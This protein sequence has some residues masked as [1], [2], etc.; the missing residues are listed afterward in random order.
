MRQWLRHIVLAAC[1]LFAFGA[2]AQGG[3]GAFLSLADRGDGRIDVLFV[4]GHVAFLAGAD[5]CAAV[6]AEGMAGVGID[7]EGSPVLPRLSRLV[8]L[9]RGT[10]LAL[11][12]ATQTSGVTVLA[13]PLSAD[14]S[15]M[16]LR[17]EAATVK[18]DDARHAE[19]DKGPYGDG[20]R[21][22]GGSPIAIV[23]LG[24]MA[25]REVY[26]IDANPA[27]YEPARGLLTMADTLRAALVA[28]NVHQPASAIRYQAPR[29]L[30]VAPAEFVSGLAPF[31]QWKRQEGF[32]VELLT[33]AV[34]HPDS[35]R[36]LIGS[37]WG[38]D[39]PEYILLV[40]DTAQLRPFTGTSRPAGISAH[41]T[42]LYFAEHTGDY[43][44]DACLGRWPVA[45]SAALAAVVGKTIAYERG[46]GLDTAMLRRVLLVAG[47]EDSAPAP[48]TTNGQVNYLKREITAVHPE[49]DTL[50]YYNPSSATRREAILADAASGAALLNYTAHCTATQWTSPAVDADDFDSAGMAQPMF[51][52]NNC[53]R[54][55]NFAADCMGER[56]LLMPEGGAIGVVGATNSTLWNEDYYW[57]VGPK[58]PF[59]LDPVYD[60]QRPGAFDRWLGRSGGVETTGQL[61]HA[62]NMAVSAYGSPYD[63]FYWEIYCL[64]GD[65]SLRPFAGH[66]EQAWIAI[67]SAVAAGSGS[68]ELRATP[69]AT[70]TAVAGGRL[71][72]RAVADSN[73][74]AL[75]VLSQCLD[76]GTVT[77]TATGAG[78]LPCV[79]DTVAVRPQRG[80]A[81]VDVAIADSAVAFTLANLGDDT[82]AGLTVSFAND[83]ACASCMQIDMPPLTVDSLPAGARVP[84]Q[85]TY[86]IASI[87]QWPFLS[88][89]LTV[90]DSAALCTLQLRHRLSM[91][92][93]EL[94]I[95]ILN[96]DSSAADTVQLGGQY[97]VC[98]TATGAYD[99]LSLAVGEVADSVGHLVIDAAVSLGG[100]SDGG[101]WYVVCG[102]PDE[103]FE[104]GLECYPWQMGGTLGW[105]LDST[106]THGGR[107]SLRSGP[108]GHRQTSDLSLDV[109]L[110]HAD[111]IGY[112]YYASTEAQAD[113]MYFSVDG[114]VK[115]DHWGAGSWR[116]DAFVLDAGRHTL[117]WRYLKDASVSQGSDCVWIDD[118]RLPMA[119]WSEAYGCP[120]APVDTVGIA[121]PLSP[122]VSLFPNPAV[123]S[124]S[125][126][127]EGQTLAG[128]EVR[129]LFGR[130]VASLDGG[131]PTIDLA[132]L[133]GGVYVVGCRMADGTMVY[134][135]LMVSKK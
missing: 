129:D 73:G 8:L 32:D 130:T 80:V 94:H 128:I 16:P 113:R 43:L 119:L 44:P 83:T 122:E 108:I 58:Y 109:L 124:V 50:C 85:A 87:G 79:A 90:A 14:G 29:Y 12:G 45:D 135:R 86:G 92:Y 54:S 51:F 74:R 24:T 25:D 19:P 61:L 110:P 106:R 100:W 118:L 134:K 1:F 126:K 112:W 6:H 70:V 38:V 125:V 121:S 2:S 26:R 49:V 105:Q 55:N 131:R 91:A 120:A 93:P 59:S 3:R 76:T 40:G 78:L 4:R 127:V 99:T 75:L 13:A 117:R 71:L 39:G 36:A 47:S 95:D 48:T 77:F 98:A 88:G 111:T 17:P 15:P 103:G 18:D 27:V 116:H 60:P 57:S 21:L 107:Y 20:S 34:N 65:P 104:R 68:V 7:G 63:R 33:V 66:V 132:P 133:P 115:A 9:P 84:L 82:L 52:V 5:G 22:A 123:G 28:E 97:I 46:L 89:T 11:V 62:G 35:V 67:D 96:S 102:Q 56:L 114:V 101:R 42:D 53:C 72:G 41:I 64:L 81:L 31:V 10:R 30:V 23:H 37:R 69:G